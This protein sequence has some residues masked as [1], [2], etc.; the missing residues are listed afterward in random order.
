MAENAAGRTLS[1]N[2]PNDV[3]QALGVPLDLPRGLRRLLLQLRHDGLHSHLLLFLTS[4][5]NSGSAGFMNVMD[6]GGSLKTHVFNLPSTLPGVLTTDWIALLS[7]IQQ[8]I[9]ADLNGS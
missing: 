2:C 6:C 9:P 4:T 1:L 7:L 8:W 5:S 3:G